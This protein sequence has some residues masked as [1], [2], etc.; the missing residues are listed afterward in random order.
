M[1]LAPLILAAYLMT[2]DVGG[3]TPNTN[4]DGGVLSVQTCERGVGVDAKASTSGLYGLALQ[5]GL[6]AE[7]QNWSITMTPK[8]GVAYVDHRVWEQSGSSNFE[9]GW[10]VLAGQDRWRVGVEYFHIS[11]AYLSQPNYG[12]NMLMVQVGWRI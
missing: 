4:L 8:M 9:L 12:L 2:L 6:G 5:Y 1:C 7:I 10:Q 3:S 11:N